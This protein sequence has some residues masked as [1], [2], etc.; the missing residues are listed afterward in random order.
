MAKRRV[1]LPQRSSLALALAWALA[2]APSAVATVIRDVAGGECWGRSAPGNTAWTWESGV[3]AL[4]LDT[5]ISEC[6]FQDTPVILSSLSGNDGHGETGGSSEFYTNN[7]AR[8]AGFRNYMKFSTNDPSLAN[9][10]EW[11]INWRASAGASGVTASASGA[12]WGQTTPGNTAWV[13]DGSSRLYVDIDMSECGFQDTPV[14]LS[15]IGGTNGHWHTTGS[16][17]IYLATNTTFR[18]Y[19]TGYESTTAQ[20]NTWEWHINWRASSVASGAP[21]SANGVC[22]G[23]TTPGNTAWALDGSSRLHV[24]IDTSECGFQDTPVIL[25]SIGG[26][27]GHRESRGSSE[28][29]S[30]TNTSFRIYIFHPS[31]GAPSGANSREWHI[32]WVASISAATQ[33]HN[34]TTTTTMSTTATSTTAST[35]GTTTSST[36]TTTSSTVTRTNAMTQALE[37]FQASEQEALAQ[38]FAASASGEPVVIQ[39]PNSTTITVAQR[40]DVQAAAQNGGFASIAVSGDTDDGPGGVES[41]R[42]SAAVPVSMIQQL[43]A[44]GGSGVVLMVSASKASAAEE[45][46]LSLSLSIYL[47]IYI[48]EEFTG[49]PRLG[50]LKIH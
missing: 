15:S 6:G 49:W 25:S 37:A 2:L 11:S 16:S 43:A 3:L 35:T 28:I 44:S 23:R 29:Y 34:S 45:L 39:K 41:N 1:R 18:V 32:N 46:S 12:C 24:D 31:I 9:S 20:A 48:Y 50:W 40:I 33:Y 30:P 4:I 17:E 5:D 42:V 21:M 22:V 13:Q 14:I 36:A 38:V 10:R 19:I 7:A 47:Y 8:N 27:E 26:T